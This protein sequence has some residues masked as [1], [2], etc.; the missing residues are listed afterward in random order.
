MPRIKVDFP[1]TVKWGRKQYKWRAIELSEY[2]ILLAA[3]QKELVGEELRLQLMLEPQD[4]PLVLQGVVVYAADG[5]VGVRFKNLQPS[6]QAT[7]K[8]YVQAHGIGIGR[9]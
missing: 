6:E 3:S 2:G 4:S 9:P 8:D 7:L 5:G 1:V